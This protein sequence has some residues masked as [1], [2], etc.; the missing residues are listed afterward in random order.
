MLKVFPFL[1]QSELSKFIPVNENGRLI[2]YLFQC[3]PMISGQ[4][5]D[6]DELF[7]IMGYAQYATK[8][9]SFEELRLFDY[10]LN[11]KTPISLLSNVAFTRVPKQLLLTNISMS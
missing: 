11:V 7:T 9:L 10:E 8:T 6:N 2:G 3:L 5:D 1:Q 4:L